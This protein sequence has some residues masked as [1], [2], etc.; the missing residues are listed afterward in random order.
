MKNVAKDSNQGVACCLTP[1][2]QAL[3]GVQRGFDSSTPGNTRWQ[4]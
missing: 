2:A 1:T 3:A 4:E